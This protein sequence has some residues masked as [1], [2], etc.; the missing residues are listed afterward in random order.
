MRATFEEK[1]YEIYFNCELD[2]RSR[3]FFPLGQVQEGNLGFDATSFSYNKWLWGT[4][5]FLRP[6]SGVRLR[7]IA[8]E[9]EH[10]LRIEIN[11]IPM[12]KSNLLFQYKKPDFITKAT[13]KEWQHWQQPYYRYDIYKEQ[14]DLLEQIDSAFRKKVLVT[15]ASPALHDVN[16]LVQAKNSGQIIEKSNF[17]KAISLTSHHRNTYVQAGTYSIAC[18]D[19]E[20]S[21][22]FDILAE[23]ERIGVDVAG[24]GN[25]LRFITNFRKRIVSLVSENIDFGPSFTAVNETYRNY[26]QFELLYSFITMNNFK[27]LTGIQWLVGL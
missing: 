13:G 15:Y 22:K 12:M 7:D 17:T 4:L 18:S 19:P 20:R 24:D 14:Q 10:I 16:E 21:D 3:V 23:I 25:N 8:D 9:M 11:G 6:L 2:R 5:G 26:E 1:S 27:T